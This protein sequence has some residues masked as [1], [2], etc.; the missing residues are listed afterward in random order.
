MSIFRFSLILA[1]ALFL[2]NKSHAQ[3]FKFDQIQAEGALTE[4]DNPRYV[5]TSMTEYHFG[6]DYTSHTTTATILNLCAQIAG[7]SA[8][9]YIAA[10]HGEGSAAAGRLLAFYTAT[11]QN[12]DLIPATGS[13]IA[14]TSLTCLKKV[15]DGPVAGTLLVS[16]DHTV[17]ANPELPYQGS[18][19]PITK[20]TFDTTLLREIC[21]VYGFQTLVS[22]KVETVSITSEMV[23][24]NL[25]SYSSTFS[26]IPTLV[27]PK[28]PPVLA[29][30]PTEIQCR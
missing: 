23:S 28:V 10:G 8:S 29:M 4:F 7:G 14:I 16:G 13:L 6:Y 5:D 9:D 30:T 15:A 19:Y 1:T 12:F 2:M 11:T 18:F 20:G 22:A 27:E 25:S 24:P 26:Y 3:S 21:Q 17:I